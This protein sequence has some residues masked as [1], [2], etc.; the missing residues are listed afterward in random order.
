LVYGK[1]KKEA[2]EKAKALSLRVLAQRI[3]VGDKATEME[4][5]FRVL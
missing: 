4:G 5:L 1:T 3:E 2:I